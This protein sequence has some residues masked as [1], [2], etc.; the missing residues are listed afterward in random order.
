MIC[1][2]PICFNLIAAIIFFVTEKELRF[3]RF[4]AAQ[5]LTLFGAYVVLNVGLAVISGIPGLGFI[6]DSVIRPLLGL[7]F[8]GLGIYLAMKAY[9]NEWYKVPTVGDLAER[10]ASK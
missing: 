6:T 3:V 7:A 1:Y 5:A 10:L 8:F 4:H 2:L 9:N